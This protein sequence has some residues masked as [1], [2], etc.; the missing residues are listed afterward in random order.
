[1]APNKRKPHERLQP[2]KWVWVAANWVL[3][4]EAAAIAVDWWRLRISIARSCTH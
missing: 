3:G 1:M 4:R 2:N